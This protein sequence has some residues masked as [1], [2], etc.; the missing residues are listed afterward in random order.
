ML[1]LFGLLFGVYVGVLVCLVYLGVVVDGLVLVVC[2]GCL[3]F[4]VGLVDFVGFGL[5]LGLDN[6]V[7]CW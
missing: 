5:W 2:R 6:C 7:L 1:L 4:V 3:W